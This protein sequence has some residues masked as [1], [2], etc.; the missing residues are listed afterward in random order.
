MTGGG[1][2][3]DPG[4]EATLR[5]TPLV[6]APGKIFLVGEYAVLDEGSAVVAAV[7]RHA[8][9]Q[10]LPGAEP[11]SPVVAETQA[12][13][14]TAIGGLARALPLGAVMVNTAQFQQGREKLGLGSS[15]AVAAA[16]AGTILENAGMPVADR[17]DQ[18]YAIAESGHRA[19][20]GGVGSG[21][22]VAV[23]VFGGFVRFS[24]PRVGPPRVERLAPVP[25]LAMLVFW[26]GAAAHTPTMVRGVQAFAARDA[27]AYGSLL[28]GLRRTADAFVKAFAAENVRAIVAAADAYGTL[29]G[30]LGEAAG[31]P[32]V[33]PPFADAA[34]VARAL[35]GAAKPSG[36]GGGDV[37][38]GFFPDRAAAETFATRCSRELSVLDLRLGVPGV[39]RKLAAGVKI[40]QKGLNDG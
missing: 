18:V 33:T 3:A 27:A 26:S 2:A 5:G 35:G 6:Q 10:Y 22:D 31:V 38:V 21:A 16:V 8:V 17:L 24:R 7:S 28:H 29:M 30:R 13:A 11:A 12:A 4:I 1:G 39:S 34:R 15:A 19:A 37:G 14:I 23:S 20:Q 25:R 36:A 40:F 9:G 32:I